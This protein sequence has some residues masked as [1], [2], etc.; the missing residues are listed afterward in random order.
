MGIE[1]IRDLWKELLITI[2][3]KY[4]KHQ[5]KSSINPWSQLKFQR[6]EALMSNQSILKQ[7]IIQLLNPKLGIKQNSSKISQ[8]HKKK[9][10]PSL[11]MFKANSYLNNSKT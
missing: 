7:K 1:V 6:V 10:Y 3:S 4:K 5:L 11:K 9:H 8:S 2:L